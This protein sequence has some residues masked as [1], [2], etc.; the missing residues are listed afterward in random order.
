MFWS[1]NA[2]AVR[3]LHLHLLVCISL[4]FGISHAWLDFTDQPC[5]FNMTLRSLRPILSWKLK[6]H[7]IVPTY[8]KV[9]HTIMSKL[10]TM[11]IVEGCTNIT[12]PSCDVMDVLEDIHENYLFLL[13][14]FRGGSALDNCSDI[15]TSAD[16]YFEP[17][18]F[19]I[20]GFTDLINVTVKFP[21]I[22]PKIFKKELQHSLSLVISEESG[23][24]VKTHKP[25]ITGNIGGNFS[26]VI[27]K[28][29]PNSNYCVSVYFEPK[30]MGTPIKSPLKC[31]FLQSRQESESSE[32]A[33]IGGIITVS[34]IAVVFIA[35]V[36]TLKRV[37]YICLKNKFPKALNFQNFLFWVF[38]ELPPSEAV[39]VVE[40]ICINRM[41]KLWNYNYD[42]ESDS[43]DETAPRANAGGYTT[44]GLLGRP[45]NQTSA[46]SATSEESQSADGDAKESDVEEPDSPEAHAESPTVPRPALCPSPTE[47]TDERTESPP[48]DPI[49]DGDSSSTGGSGDRIV[50][51]VD[52]KSVFMRVLDDDT[53]EA[54]VTFSPPPEDIS[55]LED[56]GRTEP[57]TLAAGGDGLEPPHPGASFECQW[58]ADIPSERS[59]T[60]DSDSDVGA[61]GDY[62]RR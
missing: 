5:V 46:T 6:N 1:P 41:K 19:E 54:P 40:V 14:G 25:K 59:D 60:S 50:F 10:D 58:P 28:L 35:T 8:Y 47:R 15:F 21:P 16:M 48:Q 27:D 18:E 2:S 4:V 44:H 11:K 17:P 52:L 13:E 23:G 34:V 43:D 45:L 61:G 36:L 29:I 22:I 32:S 20:A 56:P 9:Q 51:N 39:D 31:T 33:K 55:D 37:G 30:F 38:P 57:T 24:I 62:I 53:E 7:P 26:Y 12:R 3:S 49:P 42:D